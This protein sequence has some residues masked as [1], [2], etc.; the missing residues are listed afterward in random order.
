MNFFYGNGLSEPVRA[1]V[2]GDMLLSMTHDRVKTEV[3]SNERIV[4]A[5]QNRLGDN[6][7]GFHKVSSDL[8]LTRIGIVTNKTFAPVDSEPTDILYGGI[9]IKNSILGKDVVEVS[10][11]IFRQ[12]CSNGAI[13]S[14]SLGKYTRKK[15]N[16]GLEPWIEEIIGNADTLL[17]REFERIRHLTSISVVGHVS[18]VLAG[19]QKDQH[20][21]GKIIEEVQNQAISSNAQTM[22]DLWNAITRVSTHS[23]ISTIASMRLAKI[24]GAVTKQ[25]ELCCSCHRIMA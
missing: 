15:H 20:I 19:I 6:I 11:Y 8:N 13:T 18:E 10:P 12:W 16:G 17:D 9:Q 1:V 2:R 21:S 25:H 14:E 5:A 4:N 22:Y 3:I 23:Q 24:A 7:L